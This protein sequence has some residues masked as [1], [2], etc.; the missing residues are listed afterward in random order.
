[1]RCYRIPRCTES[2]GASSTPESKP[3]P[4]SAAR[5]PRD[6]ASSR[7]R[8]SSSS[9]KRNQGRESAIGA[10]RDGPKLRQARNE[11]EQR[12]D[13]EGLL[14]LERQACSRLP[15]GGGGAE[16]N[17]PRGEGQGVPKTRG[18]KRDRHTFTLRQR[19]RQ[20][21][22]GSAQAQVMDAGLPVP[23]RGRPGE[24]RSQA[25]GAPRVRAKMDGSGSGGQNLLGGK[26]TELLT[27]RSWLF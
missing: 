11:L 7:P 20:R 18:K 17:D 12:E 13:A 21:E 9:R 15:A 6:E 3:L 4:R 16:P 5:W 2:R 23:V 1:M 19:F 14:R 22:A 27:R 25:D 8:S 26:L 10:S 24:D